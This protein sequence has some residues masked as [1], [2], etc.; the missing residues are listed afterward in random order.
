MSPELRI[1]IQVLVVSFYRHHAGAFLVG[2]LILFGSVSPQYHLAIM[3]ALVTSS[4]LIA[5]LVGWLLYSIKCAHHSLKTLSLPENEFLTCLSLLPF[6]QQAW[7]LLIT[8]GLLYLP[9]GL[10][11]FAMMG[12]A[13]NQGIWSALL[14]IAGFNAGVCCAGAYLLYQK[15]KFPHRDSQILKVFQYLDK[16]IA[17]PYP[18]IF[19]T[20]LLR[21]ETIL[22]FSTKVFSWF[23]VAGTISLLP[24]FEYDPRALS[25]GYLLS[26]FLHVMLIR[27]IREFEESKLPLMRNLP[28]TYLG[29]YGR[30]ALVYL[31]ILTPEIILLARSNCPLVGG[32]AFVEYLSLC[33]SIC[34]L[35]HCSMFVNNV[36]TS[37]YLARFLYAFVILYL[38]IMVGGPILVLAAGMML[39]AYYLLWQ[40]YYRYEPTTAPH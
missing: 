3:E 17:K 22:L 33:L 36:S 23:I 9:V 31:G 28:Y 30:Y 40:L 15:I 34:L 7:R 11:G 1:L 8:Q 24:A 6:R 18:V 12:V 14:L 10:Y 26:A 20:Y 19:W 4:L 39:A 5:A 25:V 27:Q 37:W 32:I 29:R 2:F 13:F 35:G 16:Q 21:K 38:L